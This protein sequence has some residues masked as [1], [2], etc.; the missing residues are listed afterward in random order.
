MKHKGSIRTIMISPYH[1][2][3]GD[4]IGVI[5]GLGY[6]YLDNKLYKGKLI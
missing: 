3:Q 1:Y 6:I 4:F 5:K 2:V